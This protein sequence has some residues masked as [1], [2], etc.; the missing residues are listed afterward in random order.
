MTL[1]SCSLHERMR[2]RVTTA[3]SVKAECRIIKASHTDT[4]S[5]T[6]FIANPLALFVVTSGFRAR[7]SATFGSTVWAFIRPISARYPAGSNFR[8]SE[9]I[10]VSR[11][12]SR[13]RQR[14]GGPSGRDRRNISMACWANSRASAIPSRPARGEIAGAFGCGTRCR[15]RE[16]ARRNSRCKSSPATWTYFMLISALTWPR[17]V[18]KAGKLTPARTISVAYVC[19]S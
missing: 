16:R 11:L 1:K 9:R 14:R 4:Q 10:L 15:G 18:I 7:D 3:A 19:L 17:S 2:I 5:C 12:E 8:A 6:R 13:S